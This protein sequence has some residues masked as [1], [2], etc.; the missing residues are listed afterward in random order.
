MLGE[1]AP[2]LRH[3]WST[4]LL[5]NHSVKRA[6]SVTMAHRLACSVVRGRSGGVHEDVIF[7]K[8]LNV[9]LDLVHIG[10]KHFLA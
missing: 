1:A 4:G 5:D 6:Y 3:A 9:S 7:L 10:F 2:K 8:F